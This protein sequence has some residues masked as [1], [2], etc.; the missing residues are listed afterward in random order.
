MST[1]NRIRVMLVDD[2]PVVRQGLSTFL[3]AYDDLELVA[4]AAGGLEALALCEKHHPDVVI[5]D[6]MMPEM[7]GVETSKRLL[8]QHPELRI[9][10]LTSFKDDELVAAALE[11]GAT[12]YLLKNT[13]ADELAAA[14]RAAA[15][16]RRT[17]APE[18]ADALIRIATT[19]PTPGYDLTEQEHRVLALLVKG[20]NN[21]EIGEALF[22]STATAKFH[23]GNILS[24]LG[25]KTRTEAAALAIELG[26]VEGIH[27]G[28][29]KE[30]A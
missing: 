22:I 27:K 19:P 9:V 5:M 26:L 16:S 1:T 4:E 30:P 24:K 25:V 21:R 3:L 23:V 28:E 12:S 7:D 20:L 11:A 14:I 17:L 18:A 2:Q 8:A 10:V 6:L 29:P 13:T 15:Q